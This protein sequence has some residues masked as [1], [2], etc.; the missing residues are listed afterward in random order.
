M[1][2]I[3]AVREKIALRVYLK[4]KKFVESKNT[5]ENPISAHLV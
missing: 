3:S 4:A 1:I 2:S 5:H